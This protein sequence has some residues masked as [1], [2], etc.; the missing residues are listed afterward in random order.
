MSGSGHSNLPARIRLFQTR[1]VLRSAETC[2]SAAG[3]PWPINSRGAD[4]RNPAPF[5]KALRAHVRILDIP[6]LGMPPPSAP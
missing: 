1:T 3:P 4:L 5:P 6:V 2:G